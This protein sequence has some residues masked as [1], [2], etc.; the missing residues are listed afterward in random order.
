MS[1]PFFDKNRINR[2]DARELFYKGVDTVCSCTGNRSRTLSHEEKNIFAIS[3]VKMGSR[4]SNVIKSCNGRLVSFNHNTAKSF[5]ACLHFIYFIAK[6]D[7]VFRL[8]FE[9]FYGY[10]CNEAKSTFISKNDVAD[11]R[12]YRSSRNIFDTA[13]FATREYNLTAYQHIFDSTI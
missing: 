3:P 10:L 5:E 2:S 1:K 13:Y 9:N 4:V 8:I 7:V 6:I 11:I 12:S